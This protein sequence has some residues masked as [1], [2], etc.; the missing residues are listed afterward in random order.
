MIDSIIDSSVVKDIQSGIKHSSSEVGV[1]IP[2]ILYGS[3]AKGLQRASSDLDLSVSI[4]GNSDIWHDYVDA[5]VNRL[6]D[7]GYVFNNKDHGMPYDVAQLSP[8]MM[9]LERL[10][11]VMFTEDKKFYVIH[12]GLVETFDLDEES[13]KLE[14]KHPGITEKLAEYSSNGLGFF[15]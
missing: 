9:L 7:K 3:Y 6:Q 11:G 10:K 15:T 13:K 14:V 2:V 4:D 12:P 8:G 1:S 5:L